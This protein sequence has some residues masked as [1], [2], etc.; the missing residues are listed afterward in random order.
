MFVTS[1]IAIMS[2]AAYGSRRKA[3]TTASLWRRLGSQEE[4][5]SPAPYQIPAWQGE[6]D[7]MARRPLFV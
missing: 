2:A 7:A 6:P 1:F 3:G 4:W 5:T